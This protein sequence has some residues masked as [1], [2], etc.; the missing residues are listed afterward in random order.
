MYNCVLCIVLLC[1]FFVCSLL[2]LLPYVTLSFCFP[3]FVLLFVVFFFFL[4]IL[5]IL[6]LS[7]VLRIVV[8][9]SFSN[10]Y[11]ARVGKEKTHES[12]EK[13]IVTTFIHTGYYNEIGGG[14]SVC[15]A[16]IFLLL[17]WDHPVLNDSSIEQCVQ[18][19]QEMNRANAWGN[20]GSYCL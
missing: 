10:E 15:V 1:V 2:A 20:K 14:V 19:L 4:R 6:F 8:F 13:C 12:C 17:L 5:C 3:F 16:P 7:T 18:V 11:S 9:Y